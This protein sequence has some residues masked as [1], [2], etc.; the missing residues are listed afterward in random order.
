M[1]TILEALTKAEQEVR[2][3]VAAGEGA[4]P[5]EKAW[6]TIAGRATQPDAKGKAGSRLRPHPAAA[7][8]LALL[9]LLAGAIAAD[10][11]LRPVTVATVP[12]DDQPSHARDTLQAPRPSGPVTL[13][14]AISHGLDIEM[15]LIREGSKLSGSYCYERIGKEISLQ[16]AIGETGSLVLE[17]FVNGRKTGTFT[18]KVVSGPR[19]EGKWSKPGSTRSRDFFLVSTGLPLN[20]PGN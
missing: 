12:A 17:E 14:G 1:S 20:K 5:W 15:H 4:N 2:S 3:N 10:I 8:T 19:I 11:R 18:G 7:I 9:L 6:E 13:R 16:G